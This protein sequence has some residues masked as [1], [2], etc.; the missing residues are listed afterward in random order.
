MFIV[1]RAELMCARYKCAL[2]AGK[3]VAAEGF[4]T[5]LLVVNVMLTRLKADSLHKKNTTI[6]PLRLKN[7]AS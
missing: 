1:V 7:D 3:P 4:L 6:D 2:V 5:F